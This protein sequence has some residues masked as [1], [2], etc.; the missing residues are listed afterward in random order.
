MAPRAVASGTRPVPDGYRPGGRLEVGARAASDVG[1]GTREARPR[2]RA[3]RS[4]G[5]VPGRGLSRG[6]GH[7]RRRGARVRGRRV[8]RVDGRRGR[9]SVRAGRVVERRA[10]VL[11]HLRPR[12]RRL[13]VRARRARERDGAELRLLVHG[14]RRRDGGDAHGGAAHRDDAGAV[15]GAVSVAPPPRRRRGG[16]AHHVQGEPVGRPRLQG[17][18]RDHARAGPK[19]RAAPAP[20]GSAGGVARHAGG[21][22]RNRMGPRGPSA[23]PPRSP[24]RVAEC[25][26]QRTRSGRS[27]KRPH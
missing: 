9:A 13:D 12:A 19:P 1:R 8:L 2:G 4:C 3:N 27:S 11:P 14:Q 25:V 22:R 17:A 16:R 10:R 24:D 23:R 18:S 20:R 26:W 5:R 21:D 6:L 7:L 15:R